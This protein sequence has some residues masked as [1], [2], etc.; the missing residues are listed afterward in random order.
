MTFV[1]SLTQII[2][3]LQLEGIVKD[4][5]CNKLDSCDTYASPILY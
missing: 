1:R 2:H 3:K 5:I 4:M